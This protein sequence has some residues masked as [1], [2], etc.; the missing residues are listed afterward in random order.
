MNR[1]AAPAKPA[2]SRERSAVPGCVLI[3]RVMSALDRMLVILTGRSLIIAASTSLESDWQC[4]SLG[5]A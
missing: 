1:Q 4:D 3:N 2:G 5:P